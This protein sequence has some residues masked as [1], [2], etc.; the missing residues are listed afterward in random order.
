MSEQSPISIEVTG[1]RIEN[2]TVRDISDIITYVSY[3]NGSD[4]VPDE[5][6][7]V[8]TGLPCRGRKA[9]K[10]LPAF[11]KFF[12]SRFEFAVRNRIVTAKV[13]TF[14]INILL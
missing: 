11:P 1:Q 5:V 4:S 8:P 2:G 10:P 9:G 3:R 6:F 7:Q 12:S 14:L 13:N